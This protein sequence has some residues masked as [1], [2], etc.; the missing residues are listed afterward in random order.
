M[1]H[2]V[3]REKQIS[4]LYQ[5]VTPTVDYP[6]IVVHGAPSSGKT[7]IVKHVLQ[8]KKINNVYVSCQ[9]IF[10]AKLSISLNI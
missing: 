8:E 7:T 9:S 10:T 1:T 3:G 4:Q 6:I 2:F 5:L